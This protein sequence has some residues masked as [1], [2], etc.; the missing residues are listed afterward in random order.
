MD[1]WHPVVVE[2]ELSP[3]IGDLLV[4]ASG[5]QQLSS[6]VRSRDENLRTKVRKH[7]VA[8]GW[9]IVA[10][11]NAVMAPRLRYL[12][13]DSSANKNNN[14]KAYYDS[15][16]LLV[17]DH[18]QHHPHQDDDHN[19]E[20]LMIDGD[21][22][23]LA[24]AVDDEEE[25]E[26]DEEE[27]EEEY[28][29]CSTRTTEEAEAEAQ[30][31]N[32]GGIGAY[33][34]LMASQPHARG[35][36]ADELRASAKKQLESAGWSFWMKLKSNGR[37][38]LRYKAPTGRSYMSLHTACLAFASSHHS[39]HHAQG[40]TVSS[41]SDN[42]KKRKSSGLLLINKKPTNRKRKRISQLI[43]C[44]NDKTN[45]VDAAVITKCTTT[46]STTS[47]KKKKNNKVVGEDTA[48][49]HTRVLRPRGKD[50]K[51]EQQQQH[52][53]TSN[54]R[55]RTLL[56]VLFDKKILMPCKD[57]K[58]TCRAS[59]DGP[60]L[61]E[62]FITG[63]G[64][65]CTCCN[66]AFTVAE[67]E[68]HSTVSNSNSNSSPS[69][70]C[71]WGGRMF[72]RDGRSLAQCLVQLMTLHNT[73]QQQ[74]K[75]G[76]RVKKRC[77]DL[78]GDW[79][80]SICHHGGDLLLCDHCPSTFH[81]QCLGL[82][83]VPD[84]DWSCPSC[85]CAICDHSEFDDDDRSRRTIIY[86][87]QCERE[88]HVGCVNQDDPPAAQQEYWLC[89]GDCSRVFHHLQSLV[90]KPPVATAMEGVSLVLLKSSTSAAI[91]TT[92]ETEEES[93]AALHHARLCAAL[94]VLHEC[95]VTLI[96]PRTQSD[97]SEDMVFNRESELRRLHF[98]GYYMVGLEKAGE[99]V[100]VATLRVYGNKVAE[101]PLVGT[102]FAHRRQGLCRLLVKEV[103]R[104]LASLGVQRLLLPSVPEL[105]QTWTGSSFG[106]KPMTRT[107]KL[108]IAEHTILCFQG[109]TMCHKFLPPQP[110]HQLPWFNQLDRLNKP[111]S[112]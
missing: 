112:S 108:Q 88:F 18:H 111:C 97:L 45:N 32:G 33:M 62:G 65:R 87:D 14:K 17:L 54:R 53:S 81:P 94:D 28:V 91:M 6:L 15:L 43:I 105:L 90:G 21:N 4:S 35:P 70:G 80:C 101:L 107:D 13:P 38:E 60:P 52:R 59:R 73:K 68:A 40:A 76:V 96:E 109:T 9:R 37:E 95:F 39:A 19:K 89:S 77:T 3:E 5:R 20:D 102:R 71:C 100:T 57:R 67:F 82:P 50:D 23:T 75:Q 64:V 25:E 11:R 83:G 8:Q 99:L 29:P 34:A 56:S 47:K 72:L 2:A 93:E 55:S 7:L 51:V 12:S 63:D 49:L 79:V 106:F 110:L 36:M 30:E 66:K 22:N 26:D 24:L 58:V 74:E 86:C 103:E 27:E 84:G 85:R 98:R 78:D 46:T 42:T 41:S 61:K 1:R 44:D 31:N 48:S 69:E 92:V 16:P 104:M 10:K